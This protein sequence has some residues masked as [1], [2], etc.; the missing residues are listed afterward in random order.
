MPA[1][2]S[3]HRLR[4]AAGLFRRPELLAFLPAI[5]LAASWFGGKSWLLVTA[6]MVPLAYGLSGILAVPRAGM[7]AAAGVRRRAEELADTTPRLVEESGQQ[8]VCFVVVIDDCAELARRH[9]PGTIAHLNAIICARFE[10]TLRGQDR[11]LRLSE[12]RIMLV[13]G[14]PA[15]QPLE[16]VLQLAGRL[17]AMAAVPVEYRTAVFHLSASVGF[18]LAS[19]AP[20]RSGAALLSAAETA[21]TIAWR[22]GPSGLRAYSQG[23][24]A[25]QGKPAEGRANLESALANG[26]IRAFFQPQVDSASGAVI[27]FEALARWV[28]PIRGLIPPAEFLPALH[29]AGLS[30]RL[31]EVMVAQTLEALAAWDAA[32]WA[33]PQ[34]AVNFSSHELRNPRLATQVQWELDR[35]DLEPHRLVVEVL[36]TVLAES[37]DDITVQNVGRLAR[38]GCGVDLDDFGTGHAAISAI[39]RFSV[40]RLKVD[41]SFVSGIDHMPEQQRIVAA[42]LSMARELGLAVLAEG[43]ETPEEALQLARMGCTAMQGFGIAPPMPLEDSFAWLENRSGKPDPELRIA[44]NA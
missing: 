33:V 25:M 4:S 2:T 39:R 14:A 8:V 19:R 15:R 13:I 34:A 31:G 7:G 30:Q 42:I 5:F 27:G 9:G 26:E 3:F 21:A 24:G 22:N 16:G 28:H 6:L 35:F 44:A 20:A 32:G 18:C 17:Q 12:D 38:I 10:N 23:M 37:D 36:E 40:N 1:L 29:A 11:L 41:R 43:V